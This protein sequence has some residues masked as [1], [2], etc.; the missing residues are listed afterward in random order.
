[1][2]TNSSVKKIITIEVQGKN[3]S[4]TIDGV[5][6]SFQQLNT[7]INKMKTGMQDTNMATGS[8]S[9]TV[10][11]LGRAVSDSNY[12][13]RGMAN[14]LSQLASNF[15]Y[16]TKSAGTLLGG[17]KDIGKALMGPLGVIL[18]FQ[19]AI[20]MLER[21]SMNTQKATKDI[22]D[23][24][25]AAGDAASDL[26]IFLN[27]MKSGTMTN[28][29]YA[30]SV[31]NMQNE[32]KDLN[33][34]LDENGK[35]TK[36]SVNAIYDKIEALQ[37]LAR[38]NA[39][40]KLFEENE[41]KVLAQQLHIQELV[42]K[43]D[44]AKQVSIEEMIKLIEQ[45]DAAAEEFAEKEL[46]R[47]QNFIAMG[48]DFQTKSFAGTGA[49]IGLESYAIAV[50]ELIKLEADSDRIANLVEQV[51]LL[52]TPPKETG[53]DGGGDSDALGV[54]R[55]MRFFTGLHGRDVMEMYDEF[56]QVNF[57]LRRRRIESM[58]LY[59]DESRI[60]ASEANNQL[61]R[62]E[63]EHQE[64][65][66]Q[67]LDVG[68]I[69]RHEAEGELAIMRMDLQDQE[70]EHEMLLLDLRMQ[71]QLEY[72]E[73]VSGLGQVFTTLGKE[74][75]ALATIGLVVQKGAA[76]AGVVIEAQQANAKILSAS[77]TEVGFYKAAAAATALNPF[78]SE[79]YAK[80]AIDAEI[81]AAKR[82]TKNNV[83]AG[84][85]I[86]NILATTLT[87]RTAPSGGGRAGGGAGGGGGRTFDFN[88]VGSTGTNQ[89]A[90]AVGGQFQ[91]PIQA[92]V[93]SNEMTSQQELDLQ[94]QTGASLGD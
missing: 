83:G 78:A 87:S 37:M 66:L 14:N 25:L 4:V 93:V 41:V 20:A 74:S 40:S 81:G 65:M 64:R 3:A 44:K 88:L 16:T 62:D 21:F 51:N 92:Y 86:A 84:I 29:D 47:Q 73:F 52:F 34:A 50:K 36:Q 61:L 48:K 72:V 76:V 35:L 46:E 18:L 42:A 58:K 70:F 82:I 24:K 79:L 60:Q 23:F 13:I 2:A 54:G 32:Y 17:L 71:A 90:E 77:A 8:A 38:V 59:N 33:L 80:K 43:N 94:I 1:M 56:E 26:K 67:T 49:L 27:R 91:E 9:A 15:I 5:K 30:L 19:G 85:A 63:I 57:S 28:E 45:E 39:V 11:E 69:K 12:G 7:E 55:G 75:E 31:K 22:Q 53:D 10:L 6:S 89:L 68:D